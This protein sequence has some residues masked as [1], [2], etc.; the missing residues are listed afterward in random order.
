M[1]FFCRGST[2]NE[3]VE[4]TA[5]VPPSPSSLIYRL[6]KKR[7]RLVKEIKSFLGDVCVGCLRDFRAKSGNTS[8]NGSQTLSTASLSRRKNPQDFFPSKSFFFG[9][10]VVIFILRFFKPQNITDRNGLAKERFS[11]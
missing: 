6:H 5:R 11:R 2:G 1:L 3:N 7:R 8:S 10:V 4:A 9:R